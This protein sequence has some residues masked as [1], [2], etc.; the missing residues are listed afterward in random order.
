M[1]DWKPIST[2]PFDDDLQLSVIVDN[3]VYALA[4][5]C[6]R[7]EHGWVNAKTRKQVFVEPTHWRVWSE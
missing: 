2:A 4:F 5:P 3:E 7:T 1:S 6:R